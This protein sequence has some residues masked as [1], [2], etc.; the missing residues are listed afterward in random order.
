MDGA[1]CGDDINS[2]KVRRVSRWRFH[3]VLPDQSNVGNSV[4]GLACAPTPRRHST[5]ARRDRDPPHPS[6]QP[7]APDSRARW[8][9][10]Q[11]SRRPGRT[12]VGNLSQPAGRAAAV[13]SGRA[14]SAVTSVSSAAT[15]VA[16]IS[17]LVSNRGLR[18]VSTSLMRGSL[19][20]DVPVRLDQRPSTETRLPWP[21]RA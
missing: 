14:S 11:R 19:S 4:S 12:R 10:R 20:L 3:S 15:S 18:T 13:G 6:I 8:R 7:L 5:P 17:V 9:G 2:W 1:L 21:S 16:L